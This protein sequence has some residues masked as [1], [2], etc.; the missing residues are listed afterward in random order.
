MGADHRLAILAILVIIIAFK[1]LKAFAL[2]VALPS[3]R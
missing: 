1:L 3:R 2:I